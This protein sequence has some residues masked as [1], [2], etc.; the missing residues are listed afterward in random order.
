MIIRVIL[1]IALVTALFIAGWNVY[2]RLPNDPDAGAG[3]TREQG[4]TEVT[5]IKYDAPEL[6]GKGNDVVIELFPID[7][8][9]LRRDF[10]REPH[11]GRK[12]EDFLARRMKEKTPVRAQLD[13]T[14]RAT[15][16]LAQGKWWLHASLMSP[17]NESME[18]RLPINVAAS[19]QTIEL[20]ADNAYERTKKF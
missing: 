2:R 5:I 17:D 9:A 12:F 4:Q 15:I 3:N 8:E 16:K 13:T 20:T 1:G 10:L 6:N 7:F 19:K 14:G 11:A 18:W